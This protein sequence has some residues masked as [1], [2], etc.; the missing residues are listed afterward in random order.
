MFSNIQ[1]FVSKE[2]YEYISEKAT[3]SDIRD[4]FLDDPEANTIG[5]ENDPE[6]AKFVNSIPEDDGMDEL[7]SSDVDKIAEE[8]SYDFDSVNESFITTGHVGGGHFASSLNS[9]RDIENS[10]ESKRYST[11]MS[12]ARIRAI[13]A[14]QDGDNAKAIKEWTNVKNAYKK[15]MDFY[16]KACLNDTLVDKI[17]YIYTGQFILPLLRG[18]FK[19][20]NRNSVTTR[21]ILKEYFMLGIYYCDYRIDRNKTGNIIKPLAQYFGKSLKFIITHNDKKYFAKE[22][23]MCDEFGDE[24][25]TEAY[26]F[27]SDDF[28]NDMSYGGFGGDDVCT[29]FGDEFATES[30]DDS[31][32]FESDDAIVDRISSS[33][34]SYACTEF[35]DE[36]STEAYELESDDTITDRISSST[37]DEFD[38]DE[39]EEDFI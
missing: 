36:F 3:D 38:F 32:E 34:E 1:N 18:E 12:E 13:K 25:A 28:I 27:E 15:G 10:A 5:A 29:E 8:A 7:T 39:T 19:L 17:S 35:G 30:D 22:S 11:E 37:C 16:L 33:T 9:I 26:D 14:E 21:G 20:I 4:M 2:A 31:Y 24:F 23:Y 6:V